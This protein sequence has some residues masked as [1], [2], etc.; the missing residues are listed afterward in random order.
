MRSY[1]TWARSYGAVDG[2]CMS[3]DVEWLSSGDASVRASVG[4]MYSLTRW[5]LV[6]HLHA[7]LLYASC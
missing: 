5:A 3:N 6:S 2:S 7:P 1:G 4:F